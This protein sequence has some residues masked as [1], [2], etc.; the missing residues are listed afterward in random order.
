MNASADPS[1]I[2]PNKHFNDLVMLYGKNIYCLNL[3]KSRAY[4]KKNREEELGIVF[5]EIVKKLKET[6]PQF[7][8]IVY[9]HIDLKNSMKE[10]RDNF[11]EMAILLS[12]DLADQYG[13]FFLDGFS[14]EAKLGN[15][16][17]MIKV[18]YQKGIVRTNCVDCLD[19]TN[20]MQNLISERAFYKQL[21]ICLRMSDNFEVDVND[22]VM[23]EF[24]EMWKTLGDLI[25]LQYGGSKAHR[26]K[27]GRAVTKIVTS[28]K[29]HV[30][31]T[32]ADNA[33]QFN[34]SLFLGEIDTNISYEEFLSQ[35]VRMH[36]PSEKIVCKFEK[37]DLGGQGFSKYISK[38]SLKKCIELTDSTF[39]V[40]Y[41]DLVDW[42][43]EKKFVHILLDSGSSKLKL[44]FRK[45]NYTGVIIGHDE[46]EPKVKPQKP[47]QKGE[48]DELDSSLSNN[49][50]IIEQKL[51][52]INS[53]VEIEKFSKYL[54]S[55]FDY[56]NSSRKIKAFELY[57]KKKNGIVG[58][59]DQGFNCSWDA[60]E[61]LIDLD[62]FK[63]SEGKIVSFLTLFLRMSFTRV[64]RR[65][66]NA[67]KRSPGHIGDQAIRRKLCRICFSWS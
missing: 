16:N 9:N 4:M 47:D 61:E 48:N 44:N 52:N 3:I 38:Q 24:Q 49:R 20:L 30:S 6:Y 39:L 35:S 5:P 64:I 21:R 17:D 50:Y 46:E 12:E 56:N 45:N 15:Y 22:R 57:N 27:G 33:R 60:D 2:G 63:I 29:R 62:Y 1:Y 42:S 10:D 8:G 13:S 51:E 54:E 14:K 55:A 41:R 32:F 59:E 26:Q 31:N 65:W 53:F 36:K 40:K 43:V 11:F 58:D 25:S 23:V 7:Q 67:G 37:G 28:V 18:G 34:I 19:R 66:R